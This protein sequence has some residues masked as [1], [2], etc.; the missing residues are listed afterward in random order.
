MACH[1]VSNIKVTIT[2]RPPEQVRGHACSGNPEKRRGLSAHP[3]FDQGTKDDTRKPSSKTT[4][5]PQVKDAVTLGQFC[6]KKPWMKFPEFLYLRH[7]G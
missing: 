6:D 2:A 4:G 7:Y 5:N 3:R 1:R